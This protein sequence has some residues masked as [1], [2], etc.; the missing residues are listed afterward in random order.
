[1]SDKFDVYLEKPTKRMFVWFAAF[2]MALATIGWFS[3]RLGLFGERV[4]DNAMPNYEEFQQMYNTCQQLDQD[5][6]TVR[7]IPDDDKSF[8]MISKQ[9]QIAAKR[10]QMTRWIEEYN[11]KSRMW[12]RS[13]WKSSSLPHQLATADFKHYEN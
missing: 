6:A 12:N 5:L 3:T 8:S 13:M 7:G 11:A 2:F 10:Q 4:I 9:Q 1:M